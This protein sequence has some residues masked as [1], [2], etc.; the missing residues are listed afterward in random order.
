MKV[1]GITGGVGSGKTYVAGVMG[2]EFGACV[3]FTDSVAHELMEKGQECYNKIVEEFGPEILTSSGEL[4]KSRLS[5]LIFK[6]PMKRVKINELV[7]PAV[8]EEVRKR[9]QDTHKE[10]AVIESALLIEDHYEEICDEVWYV[11][12]SKEERIKRLMKSRGYTKE[13]CE[14]IMRNQMTEEQFR[15]ASHRVI[16]NEDESLLAAEQ[17]RELLSE[18][19]NRK[20]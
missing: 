6:D 10:L 8:K 14:D 4:D 20:G 3:I 9:I 13:K 2:Q 19:N 17:I 18:M 12:A 15:A 5:A 7:H 16:F 11:Y 1:I